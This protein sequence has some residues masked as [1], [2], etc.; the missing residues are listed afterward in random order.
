MADRTTRYT[1][2]LAE[3][4]PIGTDPLSVRRRVEAMEHLMEGL[5]VV[6]G[7][8]RRIGLDVI[9]DA[10]PFAGDAIAAVLGGWMVWEARNL[11]MPRRT[12]A[13][14]MANV[15]IDWALGLIPFVGAV[16]DFFFR[17]NSRNLKII[18]RYLEKHHPAA[19]VI[20]R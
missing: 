2:P 11:G 5:F 15:G 12:M 3:R 13:R 20:D 6:P 8:N 18:R 7:I 9:L 14:M 17:S 16:P 10:L 19:A 1:P 4:F